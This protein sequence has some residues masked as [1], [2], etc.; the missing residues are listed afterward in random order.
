[1]GVGIDSHSTRHMNG[2]SHSSGRRPAAGG[3]DNKSA[4]Q[5]AKQERTAAVISSPPNAV[6]HDGIWYQAWRNRRSE[7]GAALNTEPWYRRRKKG[8]LQAANEMKQL[9]DLLP[10]AGSGTETAVPL[11]RIAYAR[12][13]YRRVCVLL[14]EKWQSRSLPGQLLFA[15]ACKALATDA[16]DEA[17]V[18]IFDCIA[19]KLEAKLQ[20][21]E[22]SQLP[23]EDGAESAT[24]APSAV[25]GE[26]ERLPSPENSIIANVL[27]QRAGLAG[28][29]GITLPLKTAVDPSQ[30]VDWVKL[31]DQIEAK[32]EAAARR[33]RQW[34]AAQYTLAVL[35]A[36]CAS[37]A[38]I[39]VLAKGASRVGTDAAAGPTG[40][41]WLV[42]AL[43]MT[44]AVIT[45]LVVAVKPAEK[46]EAAEKQAES[47]DDLLAAITLFDD[48]LSRETVQAER[49]KNVDAA[50]SEVRLRERAARKRPAAVPLVKTQTR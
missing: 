7:M 26:I 14:S 28:R 2:A 49:T 27:Q 35:S 23:T 30:P 40:A 37:F 19:D 31:R 13:D 42:V 10:K 3:I 6:D 34:R 24:P 29:L 17:S 46:A 18:A 41:Q 25:K 8:E 39:G 11:A 45:A 15:G 20:A 33:G 21:E 47:L 16:G 4:G 38:G 1:M 12:G 48:E 32:K 5:K 43:T 22:Q 44:S 9:N 36:A 50:I